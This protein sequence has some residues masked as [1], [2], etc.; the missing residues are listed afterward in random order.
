MAAEMES[1]RAPLDRLLA[2][3]DD[4]ATL[5]TLKRAAEALGKTHR[6][7]PA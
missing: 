4:R 3:D 5:A 7:E 2:P 1:T 6:L